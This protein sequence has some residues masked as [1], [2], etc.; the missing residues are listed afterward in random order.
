MLR[1]G[2][3]SKIRSLLGW[4]LLGHLKIG[5]DHVLKLFLV[6][7]E[8]LLHDDFVHGSGEVLVHL[9]HDA[10]GV[11]VLSRFQVS[12]SSGHVNNS[13][14]LLWI[15]FRELFCW[16]VVDEEVVSDL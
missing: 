6:F 13:A 5:G 9:V 4:W 11:H 8:S 14:D 2:H 1:D 15:E 3:H 12:G 16:H 7:F 10:C